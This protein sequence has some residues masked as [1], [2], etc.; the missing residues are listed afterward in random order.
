MSVWKLCERE[1]WQRTKMKCRA[2]KKEE[3][4]KCDERME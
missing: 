2:E 1:V 4:V 3:Q